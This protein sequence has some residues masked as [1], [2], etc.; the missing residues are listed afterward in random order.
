MNHCSSKLQVFPNGQGDCAPNDTAATALQVNIW[1]GS[2][3]CIQ[4]CAGSSDAAPPTVGS[5]AANIEY[6]TRLS[7]AEYSELMVKD[8][9]DCC[10]KCSADSSCYAW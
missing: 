1:F 8:W 9:A 3:D 5:C 10:G 7:G 2:D 6:E 4:K